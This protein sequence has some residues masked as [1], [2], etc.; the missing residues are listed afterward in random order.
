MLQHAHKNLFFNAI[1]KKQTFLPNQE[2]EFKYNKQL[3]VYHKSHAR[4]HMVSQSAYFLCFFFVSLFWPSA[5]CWLTKN[6]MVTSVV[7]TT[8]TRK[9]A[10]AWSD[11]P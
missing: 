9:P 3:G 6:K 4:A 5:K 8:P 1:A 11:S 10:T 7:K 2:M